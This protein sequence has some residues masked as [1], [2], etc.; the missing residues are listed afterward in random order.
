MQVVENQVGWSIVCS[1]V[2]ICSGMLPVL[3]CL[4][5]RCLPHWW[6][7]SMARVHK[8]PCGALLARNS[9]GSFNATELQVNDLRSNSIPPPK[10]RKYNK[11]A[12][13]AFKSFSW[14]FQLHK[15]R[16]PRSRPLQIVTSWAKC[17]NLAVRPCVHTTPWLTYGGFVRVIKRSIRTS[18]YHSLH[19]SEHT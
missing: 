9:N 4:Q 18:Y 17:I 19:K 13:L 10:K 15:N 7:K 14:F 12:I 3:P 11:R 16:S 6:W 2:W 1:T 5:K 8:S